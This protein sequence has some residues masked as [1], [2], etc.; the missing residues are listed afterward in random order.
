VNPVRTRSA[1]LTIEYLG[2]LITVRG[3]WGYD[4]LWRGTYETCPISEE[5]VAAFEGLGVAEISSDLMEAADPECIFE[6][7]KCEIDFLLERPF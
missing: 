7:A 1:V 3:E 4:K 2:C 6:W 5:A